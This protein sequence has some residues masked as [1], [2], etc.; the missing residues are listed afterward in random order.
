MKRRAGRSAGSGEQPTTLDVIFPFLGKPIGTTAGV[1]AAVMV[2]VAVLIALVESHVSA[3]RQP[4]RDASVSGD[5][6]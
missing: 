3:V 2:A 4:H 6:H 1:G 5:H